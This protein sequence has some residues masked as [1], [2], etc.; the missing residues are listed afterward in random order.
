VEL[1]ISKRNE[2]KLLSRE[3]I[4]GEL[5]FVNSATPNYDTVKKALADKLKV[6]EDCIALQHIY[7][8]FGSS[9]G[10]FEARVYASK[11]ILARVEPKK[12]EKKKKPGEEAEAAPAAP[13]AKK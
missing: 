2:N 10:T 12:K 7:T 5:E 1:K 13:A 6:A 4:E 3:E 11:D 8:S 9:K